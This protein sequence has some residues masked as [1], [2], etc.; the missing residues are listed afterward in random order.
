MVIALPSLSSFACPFLSPSFLPASLSSCVT[1]PTDK[2]RAIAPCVTVREE[3]KFCL[4]YK[5]FSSIR[6]NLVIRD[7]EGI[8]GE[9]SPFNLILNSKRIF[10]QRIPI[11]KS[12][13][14][15][16]VY[17]EMLTKKYVVLLCYT[18]NIYTYTREHIHSI[19]KTFFCCTNSLERKLKCVLLS[20][21]LQLASRPW[22]T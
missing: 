5:Q 8:H 14:K 16:Y 21:M 9:K 18:G 15:E 3:Q 22:P 20:W 12:A 11:T 7:P 13:L 1:D 2:S 6:A 19:R 4:Q 17:R 10:S